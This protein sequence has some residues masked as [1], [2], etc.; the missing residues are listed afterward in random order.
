MKVAILCGG[1]GEGISCW[2]RFATAYPGPI[3]ENSDPKRRA[4]DL[5][6]PDW[7]AY[8]PKVRR[9]M[10]QGTGTKYRLGLVVWELS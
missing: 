10:F 3:W 5:S 6:G 9:R 1:A 2:G 4:E 7:L 8:S